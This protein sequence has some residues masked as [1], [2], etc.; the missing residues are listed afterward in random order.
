LDECDTWDCA[1][2]RLSGDTINALG[3]IILAGV[4]KNEG[5]V[6]SRSRFEPA[7]E[8]FLNETNWYLV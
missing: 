2:K 7:H 5:V 1:H 4:E 3:Y 6:I 8:D